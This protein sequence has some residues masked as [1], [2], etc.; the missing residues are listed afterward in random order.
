M[1]MSDVDFHVFCVE[2]S[3]VL[4]CHVVIGVVLG[5]TT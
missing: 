2:V 1:L 3:L 4:G 5:F